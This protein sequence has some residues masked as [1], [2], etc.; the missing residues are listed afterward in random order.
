[1]F[2]HLLFDRF[3]R[4]DRRIRIVRWQLQ[5]GIKNV[6]D[7]FESGRE[8]FI[9]RQGELGGVSR[10]PGL[11]IAVEAIH[12]IDTANALLC[13]PDD[14]WHIE[15]DDRRCTLKVDALRTS[16]WSSAPMLRHRGS[17][18]RSRPP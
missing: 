10:P 15:V 11:D 6:A 18:R 7:Q 12:A 2:P 1:L 14:T 16:N 5:I 8:P 4:D 17:A 13:D 3:W 9:C